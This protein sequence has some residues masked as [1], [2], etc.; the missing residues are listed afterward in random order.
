MCRQQYYKEIDIVEYIQQFREVK[1]ELEQKRGASTKRIEFKRSRTKLVSLSPDV[2]EPEFGDLPR[3]DK[4]VNF[5]NK[6]EPLRKSITAPGKVQPN[7]ITPPLSIDSDIFSEKS[8]SVIRKIDRE[9]GS[10]E[11]SNEER[12]ADPNKKFRSALRLR[13]P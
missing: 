11:N 1:A 13:K 3:R 4:K 2:D 5:S 9:L 6:V 10:I 8:E 12:K 7:L